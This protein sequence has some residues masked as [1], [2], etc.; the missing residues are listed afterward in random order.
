MKRLTSSGTPANSEISSILSNT[1]GVSV[2]SPSW[3]KL[4]NN[5]GNISSFASFDY[6]DYCHSQGVQVWAMVK[7]TDLESSDID[8]TKILTHTS[9]RQ[10][11]VNQLVSQALQ[12]NL[13]GI[14][15]DFRD[16]NVAEIGDAYIQFLREL[17]IKCENND[18]VLSTTV[19]VPEFDTGVYNYTEQ[20]YY[21]DYICLMAYD[22]YKGQAT[23]EGPVASLEWVETNMKAT[24]EE[25][26]SPEQL[27]LGIPFHSK[28]WDLTPT[29]NDEDSKYLIGF[30]NYGLT[31][32]K[33][34]MSENVS[35]P[36]WLE[37]EGQYYGEVVK[38][39][40]TYKMWLEDSSSIEKK[41]ALIKEYK[42]AGAAFWNSDLDNSSI[43]DTIIKYIN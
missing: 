16:L 19:V 43:W 39:G 17:S 20:S 22:Q 40:V 15:V 32:A 30:K 10:N 4:R 1:K 41:L 42:L 24:L 29:S 8:T 11:L 38:S 3:F 33:N 18:I 12:Y 27:L 9:S 13:D 6:V 26:I 7:N 23:G 37:K 25:G 14:N 5:K 34:W 35:D 36:T 28:L 2:V 31:A 21:V